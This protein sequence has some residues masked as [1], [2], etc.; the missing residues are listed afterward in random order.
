MYFFPAFHSSNSPHLGPVRA[1]QLNRHVSQKKQIKLRTLQDTVRSSTPHVRGHQTC[2]LLAARQQA[3]T[4]H[5]TAFFCP[6][7]LSY[8]L[9]SPFTWNSVHREQQ[10][11]TP[12]HYLTSVD[13]NKHITSTVVPIEVLSTLTIFKK[14]RCNFRYH[15]LLWHCPFLFKW[16]K[17]HYWPQL[18]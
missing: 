1:V 15:V 18:C 16:E 10:H 7:S 3:S 17:A 6:P 8:C 13:I 11:Y 4:R 5:C 12:Q 14:K 9:I 2:I